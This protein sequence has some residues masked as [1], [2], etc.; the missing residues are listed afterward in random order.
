MFSPYLPPRMATLITR[1]ENMKRNKASSKATRV[2]RYTRKIAS[3]GT[4]TARSEKGS[5]IKRPLF[6]KTLFS[7][8]LVAE[9]ISEPVS[10]ADPMLTRASSFCAR[11]KLN[12]YVNYLSHSKQ[13]DTVTR[14]AFTAHR[15]SRFDFSLRFLDDVPKIH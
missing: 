12:S 2:A 15:E 3:A 9:S 6:R 14:P 11:L 8:K 5:G 13:R 1:D 10:G 4:A 7:A